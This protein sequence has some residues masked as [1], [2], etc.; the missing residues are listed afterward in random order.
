MS[1]PNQNSLHTSHIVFS[2]CSWRTPCA[3]F[4]IDALPSVLE[5]LVPTKDLCWRQNSISISCPQQLRFGTRFS[6][7]HGELNRVTLL[8]F[9]LNFRPWQDTKATSHFAK[10]PTA[11]TAR[12]QLRKVKLYS[13]VPPPPASIPALLFWPLCAAQKIILV[14]FE[15]DYV[16]NM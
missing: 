16:C 3:L 5:L 15:K 6:E 8:Q 4:V 1:V 12:T 2:S 10:V 11:K 9:P 13:W 14:T 7:F